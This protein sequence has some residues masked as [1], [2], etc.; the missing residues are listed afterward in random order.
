V[1][2]EIAQYLHHDMNLKICPAFYS[3][4]EATCSAIWSM[5]TNQQG[6]DIKIFTSVT[7]VTSLSWAE[8]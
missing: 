8:V 2:V 7:W 1:F 5:H 3:Y 4:G 6:W